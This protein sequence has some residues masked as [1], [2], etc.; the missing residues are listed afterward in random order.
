ML[1]P[2]REH[3]GAAREADADAGAPAA[4]PDGRRARRDARGAGSGEGRGRAAGAVP[5]LVRPVGGPGG[6]VHAVGEP[7]DDAAQQAVPAGV[8]PH[9]DGQAGGA[10][11][12]RLR[13]RGPVGP[14]GA[15]DDGDGARDEQP[16]PAGGGLR[17]AVQ[18]AAGGVQGPVDGYRSHRELAAAA[19][20]VYR[21]ARAEGCRPDRDGIW[22]DAFDEE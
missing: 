11:L 16:E 7:P 1:M 22:V 13:R 12:E 18:R 20:L 3:L 17:A 4:V 6:G 9:A 2:V 10:R 19:R 15:R 21:R 8:P 14:A 5:G